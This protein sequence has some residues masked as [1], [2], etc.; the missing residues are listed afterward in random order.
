MWRKV[1]SPLTLNSTTGSFIT[2]LLVQ[3]VVRHGCAPFRAAADIVCHF[4][5][6]DASKFE[7][8]GAEI[9]I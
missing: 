9:L 4:R 7:N 3:Y 6:N 1:A 2:T 5:A 8:I